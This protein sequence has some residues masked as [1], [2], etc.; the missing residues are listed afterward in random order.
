MFVVGPIALFPKSI[1]SWN[2][3]S[4]KDVTPS[5][6]E[7]FFRL[8]PKIGILCKSSGVEIMTKV[9]IFFADILVLGMGDDKVLDLRLMRELKIKGLNVEALPTDKACTTF[10]FLNSEFRYVAAAIIP[11]E[12]VRTSDEDLF[13]PGDS[14]KHLLQDEMD[15]EM[16]S[17]DSIDKEDSFTKRLKQPIDSGNIRNPIKKNIVKKD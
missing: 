8:D 5:S 4:M 7:L 10:N 17:R 9:L 12:T 3:G 15:K 2:V 14:Q 1:F 6:L 16:F 13:G 11:P